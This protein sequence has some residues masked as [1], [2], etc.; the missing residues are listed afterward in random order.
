M[1]WFGR[2]RDFVFGSARVDL[3][4]KQA[5]HGGV[6]PDQSLWESI[7]RVGGG[8]TPATVSAILRVADTGDCRRL[9]DL[10]NESRQKDGHLHSVL[11]TRETALLGLKWELFFEGQ[12]PKSNRGR[13][14]RRFVEKALRNLSLVEDSTGDIV[15]LSRMIAH[16][17]GAIYFGF[18][19]SETLWDVRDGRMVPI[20]FRNHAPR[21]FR[22]RQ[23]DG[24]L[25]WWDENT[26]VGTDF[27]TLYPDQFICS[28]PRV[29]G[30]IACHEG[31]ARLLVWFALFRN[32]TI[33]DWLKLAELAWKPWRLGEF[34]KDSA[35]TE[36]IAALK[37][38]LA[39]MSGSGAAV[40]P[41]S[42]KVTL[43][44]PT[45]SAGSAGK[46]DH[47]TLIGVV[48]REMSKAVLGQT[49]T[50]EQGEVGSQA[51]GNVHNA[52][53]KDILESDAEHLAAIITQHL[54]APMIRLNFGPTA[55]IPQFRFI[56]SEAADIVGYADAL[57][58]LGPI[59][60]I[61]QAWARDMLGIPEPQ[62]DEELVSPATWVDV[63]TSDL[64]KP[65]PE[66]ANDDGEKPDEEKA[67]E[68]A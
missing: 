9:V 13:R 54:I 64:D 14:Q 34:K 4:R 7:S 67:D 6:I 16:L 48:G 49:L 40:H 51:L 65:D 47:N 62:E 22:F 23:E 2:A 5:T 3:R 1:S 53:R 57:Q 26:A 50:T 66:P 12:D 8:L 41:D 36:D 28:Q 58:K 33:S 15:G 56:T 35:S 18:A 21:R 27:R 61:P 17:V 25:V 63:D 55:P 38:I 45:G 44:M 46:S 30:D 32:W 11:Q 24:R 31:L 37:S 42:V 59:V 29:N 19:V 20:G 60:R 52:I 10:A 43:A 68:A 39:G